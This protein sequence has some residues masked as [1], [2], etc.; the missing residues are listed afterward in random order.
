V[1]SPVFSYDATEQFMP[2]VQKI[3]SDAMPHAWETYFPPTNQFYHMSSV[4]FGEYF[5]ST[6]IDITERKQTEMAM[7]RSAKLL[8]QAEEIANMGSSVR[9]P[10][11]SNRHG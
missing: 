2:I 8:L 7:Q 11:R 1:E 6:G 10:R 5:I 3:F 4:A 9:Y